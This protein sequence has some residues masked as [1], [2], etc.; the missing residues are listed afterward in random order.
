MDDDP[1][2]VNEGRFPKKQKLQLAKRGS[3]AAEDDAAVDTTQLLEAWMAPLRKAQSLRASF[4]RATWDEARGMALVRV[5][6]GAALNCIGVPQRDGLALHPE[7]MLYLVD[8]GALAV[9]SAAYDEGGEEEPPL[10]SKQQCYGVLG[11]QG[12]PVSRYLAYAHLKKAGFVP[13]R[14]SPERWGVTKA[15]RKSDDFHSSSAVCDPDSSG[16][17]SYDPGH[18]SSFDY[19]PTQVGSS[20]S[21]HAPFSS[22]ASSAHLSTGKQHAI[23]YD[24]YHSRKSNFKLSAPGVPDFCLAIY[25]FDEEI[26]SGHQIF[27]MMQQCRGVPLRICIDS[28]GNLSFLNFEAI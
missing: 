14:H 15:P 20:S 12:V 22:P 25:R 26:P 5:R 8:K 18:S 16:S 21:D 27:E 11:R 24:I 1:D 4:A 23:H 28:S 7:E 13:L 17:V 10:L 2:H 6:K 19:D 9:Y 3:K